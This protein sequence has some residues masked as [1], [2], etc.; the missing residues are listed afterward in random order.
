ML[1]IIN[2]FN[3]AIMLHPFLKF[4]I[5][6][7]LLLIVINMAYARGKNRIDVYTTTSDR[8]LDFSHKEIEFVKQPTEANIYIDT[9]LQYQP[10]EGFGA[11]ITGSTAYNLMQ[12]KEADR[13]RF[14]TETFS[15]KTGMGFSYVRISI[16]CSDFS[17]EEYTCCDIP[18]V[19]NFALQKEELDY[20]IPVLKT[21]LQINPELKV[22]GSP[23]TCPKWMKVENLTTQIPYDSWTGGHLN[24]AFYGDYATYFVNW[25]KAFEKEGIPICSI[26]PQNEP[27]NHLNSASLVMTWQEQLNFVKEA[28][29]PQ[30]KQAGLKTKIYAFDHNYN[31]D[32]IPDQQQYPLHIYADA[33]AADYFTGAA[34]HN[35]MGE[36]EELNRI[37]QAFPEKELIFT[38]TSIG[39]WNDGRNLNARLTDD[40]IYVG[41]KTI[42]NW[43]NGVIVWNLMLDSERGPN[44]EKGCRS[45]FGA[46]D[47][48]KQDYKTITRNSHYYII[49]HLS[50]I[51]KPGAL[52]IGSTGAENTALDYCAFMNPDGSL[53]F[54]VCNN[55]E[56][57][58]S[59]IIHDGRKT[60]AKNLPPFSV[61]SFHWK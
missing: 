4:S 24:P 39:Q 23:W 34:Y 33:K 32:N 17:L 12:M 6:G 56:E 55:S 19:E 57:E 10:M 44:R 9:N 1:L 40:M 48:D 2:L 15:P 58:Q 52:R 35:Y 53:A 47:I 29:G 59:A 25:I 13:L 5:L 7:V 22:M 3:S 37:H 8:L 50:K 21:I 27:L 38:E 49:S 61:S 30:L 51:V 41:L 18:G 36:V 60:F 20:V 54:V 26:T 31:Y 46:V 45:C 28:L 42:K 14:L 43:C 16:G 11:A